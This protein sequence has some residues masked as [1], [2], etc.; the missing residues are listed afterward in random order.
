M[1][2]SKRGKEEIMRFGSPSRFSGLLLGGL[3]VIILILSAVPTAKAVPQLIVQV[4]D[5]TGHAGQRNSVITLYLANSIDSVAAFS[6]WIQ[7]N[8]PDIVKFQT[9]TAR[10]IDT[11]YWKCLSYSGSKCLD[12][13]SDSAH[14][15]WDIRHIDT[16]LA[17]IGNID[18]VGTLISGWDLVN[19]RSLSGAGTDI[20]IT[21]MATT[22]GGPTRPP[23]LPGPT[24]VLARL[25]A[26]ILQVPDTATVRS[27]DLLINHDLLDKFNFSR[28]NGT[29]IGVKD[30]TKP[31]TNYY[32]CTQRLGGV[33][34]HYQR[35]S[36][37]PADSI[38]PHLDTVLALD[39]SKVLVVNGSLTCLPGCCI[40]SRGN[41]DGDI[42]DV[43][44]ISDLS[45]MVDFLFFNGTITQC[46]E[47]ANVDASPLGEV[48]IADLQKLIDFLFFGAQLPS[49]Y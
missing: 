2:F 5:T 13:I 39:M 8:S 30:T 19:T 41:V 12:S 27:V 6:L 42:M 46:T 29:S 10:V 34:V 9:D 21:A 35:V 18:T 33:C 23:I 24:R 45:A 25:R 4:G 26:D 15:S 32:R 16:V 36:S 22:L 47:E 7:L 17:T 31:D 38:W 20:L 11:T 43:C 49:C 3:L 40:G 48:D 14:G 44:D 1:V 37:P 28:P